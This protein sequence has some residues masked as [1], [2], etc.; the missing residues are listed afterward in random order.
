M[1]QTIRTQTFKFIGEDDASVDTPRFLDLIS[2]LPSTPST[3]KLGGNVRL[4]TTYGDNF[5]GNIVITKPA[6]LDGNGY[7]I[8]Y[9]DS[10]TNLRWCNDVNYLSYQFGTGGGTGLG[11]AL[12]GGMT[13]FQDSFTIPG[14]VS[15]AYRDIFLL[16]G[17]NSISTGVTPHS[18]YVYYPG[19][20]HRACEIVGSTCYFTDFVV[21]TMTTNPKIY[22]M[23][24]INN[25]FI[26]DVTFART[27][28]PSALER[29]GLELRHVSDFKIENVKMIDAGLLNILQCVNGQITDC[30]IYNN[31]VTRIT[32]GM[33]ISCSNGISF[34]NNE[35]FGFRHAFDSS[36]ISISSPAIRWGTNRNIK[37]TGNRAHT[38]A[39]DATSGTSAGP[40]TMHPES[41]GCEWDNNTV[42]CGSVTGGGAQMFDNRARRTIIQNNKVQMNR[43]DSGALVS[44]SNGLCVGILN[45]A[46]KCVIKNN[47]IQ[48]GWIGIQV[49]DFDDCEVTGN[50]I[51]DCQST[52]LVLR[53]SNHI[54]TN[55]NMIRVGATDQHTSYPAAYNCCI[56]IQSGST[57]NR[58]LRNDMP[59]GSNTYSVYDENTPTGSVIV[60]NTLDGYTASGFGG[61][62]SSGTESSYG[63]SNWT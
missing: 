48:G 20:L 54:V 63:A 2:K 62:D 39:G 11:T 59:K 5:F 37:W 46:H 49:R 55:N 43:Y 27:V 4:S 26:K 44:P 36:A 21:D 16:Y 23:T 31:M 3:I 8:T 22:K 51:K 14:G 12:A 41:W 10:T 7:T 60:D 47:T 24:M 28:A 52:G 15:L 35:S 34:N 38:N 18:G 13:A 50:T 33:E 30:K 17:E 9:T 53:S 56:G 6:S 29:A 58:I 25:I 32:Y 42:I 1:A 45:R 57:G 61:P 19:E 40:F